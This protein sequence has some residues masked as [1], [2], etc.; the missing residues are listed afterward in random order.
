MK[1]LPH[2]D[3]D[4]HFLESVEHSQVTDPKDPLDLQDSIRKGH[5]E[6]APPFPGK[7]LRRHQKVGRKL[8][9]FAFLLL[10]FLLLAH[11]KGIQMQHQVT[12]FVGGREDPALNRNSLPRVD[13]HGWA[14]VFDA[15]RQAEEIRGSPANGQHLDP[16]TLQQSADVPNRLVRPESKHLSDRL[17]GFDCRS[18]R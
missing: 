2:I 17:S 4:I 18:L 15:N 6:R 8:V 9:G 13:H 5:P 7:Y 11:I 14:A 3:P 1:E 12:Q 10:V 16:M